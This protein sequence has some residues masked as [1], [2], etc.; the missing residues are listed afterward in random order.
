MGITLSNAILLKEKAKGNGRVVCLGR[1]TTP[2][3]LE[4]YTSK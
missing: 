2:F 4:G 3:F 1:P